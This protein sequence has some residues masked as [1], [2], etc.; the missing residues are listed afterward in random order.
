M[1]G[2]YDVVV[3]GAG[4]AGCVV[5]ARQATAGRSVLLL[6]AGPDDHGEPPAGVT[7]P[8]FHR[9]L[10]EPGRHWPDLIAR[11]TDLQ[12]PRVYLRGRGLGGSSAVNAMLA[13]RGVP[14]DYDEWG[15]A[16]GAAGWSAAEAECWFAA[17]RLPLRPSAPAERGPLARALLAAGIGGQASLLTRDHAGHRVSAAAAYLAAA[18]EAGLE[19]RGDALVD[20]VLLDG[21]RAAGV[22]LAGGEEVEAGTVVVCAGAI[23]SP[24]VL[25]RSGVDRPGIG[26]GLQDHPS[27][28]IA[29]RYRQPPEFGDGLAV[30]A[31]L[32][33]QWREPDDLQ[34]LPVD[35]AD[36]GD[37][38]VGFVMAALM[39]VESRGTVRLRSTRPEDQPEVDFA[40]LSDERD[41]EGMHAAVALAERLL[42][43]AA[44]SRV[45][46]VLPYDPTDDGIRRG[47]G[48]YVHAS[49]TCRMGAAGDPGAVVDG[50]GRVHGHDGLWV[51]DAS[52]LP[53]VPRANTH[54]PVMMVAER[55]SAR[56]SEQLA[57]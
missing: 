8:S 38:S 21:R 45:A 26:H 47:V 5:A 4:S 13:L 25:L 1:A 18:R 34:V 11:R 28:P 16:F 10:Q 42:R 49:S 27:F 55:T 19:V 57:S 17:V 32:R 12:D 48:D 52:V 50:D 40:L 43:S 22:R 33:G 2:H 7:G 15:A 41:M 35:V 3:V 56:L 44:L 24:A 23:H 51:C 30:A 29:V 46:D 37:P 9:A 14:A 20:R 31:Y 53:R 36:P 39:R 6:E 54:L